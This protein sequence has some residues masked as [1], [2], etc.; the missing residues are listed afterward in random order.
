MTNPIVLLRSPKK[1]WRKTLRQ[2]IN[3]ILANIA[4]LQFHH[5][6]TVKATKS[7]VDLQAC[8]RRSVW[9]SENN[10]C[11]KNFSRQNS[12]IDP[13]GRPTVTWL[14]ITIFTQV[15]VTRPSGSLMTSVL[16]LIH[17]ADPQLRPAV[18]I[19]FTRVVHPSVRRS[20]RTFQN[21]TN[22]RWKQ[23]L[24]LARL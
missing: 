16:F 19:V 10:K 11:G 14:M 15:F 1:I 5:T 18:I 7:K 17:L 23:C 21:R 9:F 12:L 20:V 8:G 13:Q 6:F 22:F 4:Y 3:S 24:L 2:K